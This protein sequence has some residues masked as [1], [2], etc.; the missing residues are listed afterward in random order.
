MCRTVYVQIPAWLSYRIGWR[1]VALLLFLWN[2]SSHLVNLNWKFVSL[3]S[4][5]IRI[6]SSCVMWFP[7]IS[8]ILTVNNHDKYSKCIRDMEGSFLWYSLITLH[9]HCISLFLTLS[10]IVDIWIDTYCYL[11]YFSK[12][13][14]NLHYLKPL[15]GPS[16]KVTSPFPIHLSTHTLYKNYRN[17]IW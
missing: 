14:S 2:S 1:C 12:V 10:H 9:L 6:I 8:G 4:C 11:S 3:N 17:L 15:V 5:P 7:V 16:A 13:A